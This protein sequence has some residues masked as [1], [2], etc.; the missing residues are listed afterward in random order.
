MTTLN[1]IKAALIISK[2]NFLSNR[3]SYNRD[4]IVQLTKDLTTFVNLNN[5]SFTYTKSA[6]LQFLNK[7]GGISAIYEENDGSII[8]ELFANFV[9][10]FGKGITDKSAEES[11]DKFVKEISKTKVTTK[12]KEKLKKIEDKNK[13]LVDSGY[14]KPDIKN[15]EDDPKNGLNLGS[16]L[17]P[18]LDFNV[19]KSDAE[20]I[21]VNFIKRNKNNIMVMK[22]SFWNKHFSKYDPKKVVTRMYSTNLNHDNSNL[23]DYSNL[24]FIKK[25]EFENLKVPLELKMTFDKELYIV[26]SVKDPL[27]TNTSFLK[28]TSRKAA[29]KNASIF[30]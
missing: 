5:V 19:K 14:I 9:Y 23:G 25:D 10:L 18:L 11:F 12:N 4:Y 2:S 26:T 16:I 30:G 7:Y 22:S 27:V 21:L 13:S 29:R 20:E 8:I 6:S 1:M 28:E 15:S 17:G 3:K 24:V